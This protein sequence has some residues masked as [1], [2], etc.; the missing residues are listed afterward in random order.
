MAVAAN[1]GSSATE[2]HVKIGPDEGNTDRDLSRYSLCR[3]RSVQSPEVVRQ[4]IAGVE[5]DQTTN[6]LVRS[7]QVRDPRGVNR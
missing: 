4:H 5:M 1:L 2:R 7:G 3:A 6:E